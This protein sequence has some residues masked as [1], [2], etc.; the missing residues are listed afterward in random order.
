MIADVA[1]LGPVGAKQPVG[2]GL[3]QLRY[4]LE[5]GRQQAVS[6]ERVR[7]HRRFV[8]VAQRQP[9]R[10]RHRRQARVDLPDHRGV[11]LGLEVRARVDPFGRDGRIELEG[12]VPPLHLGGRVAQLRK[13]SSPALHA[14][15]APWSD[16]V[17]PDHDVD[18]GGLLSV[19]RTVRLN[20]LV[21]L[22]HARA[23]RQSRSRASWLL[24]TSEGFCYGPGTADPQE[25]IH[26]RIRPQR[27]GQP[28]SRS[29]A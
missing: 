16:D 23:G 12:A 15:I 27:N 6:G 4:R 8:H 5:R 9:F 20:C 13:C 26:D 2:Q 21:A 28:A 10:G 19:E 18:H 17:G 1:A 3:L 24:V 25:P 29:I 14:D 11:V 7:P 22:Q